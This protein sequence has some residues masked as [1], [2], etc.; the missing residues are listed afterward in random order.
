MQSG[1]FV[2]HSVYLCALLFITA[3][4][5]CRFHWNLVLLLGIPVPRIN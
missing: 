3:K 1:P 4:V 5:I 2:C